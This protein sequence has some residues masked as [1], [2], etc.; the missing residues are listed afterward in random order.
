MGNEEPKITDE[1]RHEIA[2]QIIEGF[3]SG[4]LDGIDQGGMPTRLTWEIA[5]EKFNN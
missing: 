1:D 5:M 3:T 4:I 2:N